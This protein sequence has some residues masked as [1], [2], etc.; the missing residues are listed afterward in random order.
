MVL[1]IVTGIIAVLLL[2]SFA[3]PYLLKMKD[4]ALGIVIVAGMGLMLWDLW[5]SLREKDE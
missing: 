5:G 3:V 4:I 1:K 2:A